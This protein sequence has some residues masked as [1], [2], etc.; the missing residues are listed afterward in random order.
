MRI[1]GDLKL[2]YQDVLIRPKRSTL[3]SR[4]EVDVTREF[5]FKNSGRHF[6]GVP[7]MTA[8]MDT[9]GTFA[10]AKVLFEYKM[11]TVLDKHYSVEQL[12]TFYNK[13]KDTEID[14][15]FYTMGILQSDLEKLNNFLK[16]V[17]QEKI[18]N[19]CIDVANGYTE[20]FV[21][22]IKLVR[23]KYPDKNIMAG[24]IATGEMAEQLVLSGADIVKIGIGPGS[25]CTTRKVTGVGYPQLSA[26]I[27]CADAAHGVGGHVCADGGLK[28]YGDIPKAFGAGADF[29]MSGNL[30]AAHDESGGE[31]V[32]KD[33]KKF[34]E[35]YGSSSKKA[36]DK[37][38]N[39]VADYR[40]SEGKEVLIEYR[41]PVKNTVQ[42]ILGGLRSACTYV[43]AKRLKEL[44]KRTTFVRVSEQLN[45]LHN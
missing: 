23:D 33:G 32:K 44:P 9:T 5:K 37:Y 14:Y 27:E 19:L 21:D 10:M 4:S 6:S 26:T 11:I 3:Q 43:G 8:N 41:G 45:N 42:G 35:Y 38:N 39:G 13:L 7:I 16:Q 29:V 20:R 18:V 31:V 30:F 24:N 36:M 40:T 25:S 34:M 15:V 2:D 12:K 1:E 28:V 22:F 17:N